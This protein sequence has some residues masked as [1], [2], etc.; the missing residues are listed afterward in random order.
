MNSKIKYIYLIIG[1]VI[2]IA[3]GGSCVWWIQNYDLKIWFS[4]SGKKQLLQKGNDMEID[5]S[6]TNSKTKTITANNFKKTDNNKK[7][8]SN[9]DTLNMNS[10]NKSSNN[11]TVNLKRADDNE[12]SQKAKTG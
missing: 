8:S 9:K 7:E 1:I 10:N 12:S 3:I 4:F 2:G 11:D 6:I 5:T